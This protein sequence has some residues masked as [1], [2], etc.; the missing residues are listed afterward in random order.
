MNCI[1]ML[2]KINFISINL[3]NKLSV[4]FIFPGNIMYMY[5]V[6][7]ICAIV[8][9]C[10]SYGCLQMFQLLL[11]TFFSLSLLSL[12]PYNSLSLTGALASP[13]SNY[14]SQLSH[15]IIDLNCTGSEDSILNCS[16]NALINS[17]SCPFDKD[18]NVFCQGMQMV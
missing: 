5:I 18:A 11:F 15:N 7:M 10:V 16:F 14:L 12:C 3:M 1:F 9:V 2:Q 8:E 17:T 4:K 6:H 13:V